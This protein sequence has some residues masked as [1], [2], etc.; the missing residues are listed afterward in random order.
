MI[1]SWKL[2]KELPQVLRWGSAVAEWIWCIKGKVKGIGRDNLDYLC[3]LMGSKLTELPKK[4][5]SLMW[6]AMGISAWC[7]VQKLSKSKQNLWAKKGNKEEVKSSKVLEGHAAGDLCAW[8]LIPR[9]HS[10]VNPLLS[11]PQL[12]TA[13]AWGRQTQVKTF[14]TSVHQCLGEVPVFQPWHKHV[15]SAVSS[16]PLLHR[17]DYSQN[18]LGWERP[19]KSLSFNH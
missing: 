5:S 8:M 19:P 15:I 14:Q 11:P 3:P 1:K 2:G 13:G 16:D 10:T 6:N 12:R 18:Y 4:S 17:G 9:S 7:G